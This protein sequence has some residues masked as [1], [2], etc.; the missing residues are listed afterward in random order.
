LRERAKTVAFLS[1]VHVV[2]GQPTARPP[3]IMAI[4]GDGEDILDIQVRLDAFRPPG[5]ED[6]YAVVRRL[7]RIDKQV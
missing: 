3:P 6:E 4:F 5:F 2:T 1:L 7:E